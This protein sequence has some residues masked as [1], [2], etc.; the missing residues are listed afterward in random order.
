MLWSFV[1]LPNVQEWLTVTDRMAVALCLSREYNRLIEA[2][3][4]EPLTA[5]GLAVRAGS[6]VKAVHHKVTR[7]VGAGLV[8]VVGTEQGKTRPMRQYRSVAHNFFIPYQ[9]MPAE[10][11]EELTTTLSSEFDTRLLRA[12]VRATAPLIEH[13]SAFGMRFQHEGD[14]MSMNLTAQGAFFDLETLLEPDQP[15]VVADWDILHLTPAQAK[16]LQHELKALHR[17]YQELSQQNKDKSRFLL[18]L[19]LCPDLAEDSF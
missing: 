17:R 18:R 4:L 10:T 2:L 9:A 8:E 14:H 5:S 12:L 6:D 13:D 16:E 15:A 11:L 19:T 3:M 7:L 1:R